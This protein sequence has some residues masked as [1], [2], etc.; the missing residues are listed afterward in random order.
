MYENRTMI[1]AGWG[2]QRA[3]YGEQTHWMIVTLAS[4][5]GQIGLPGGGFGFSYHYSNGGA[6]TTKGGKIGGITST[7]NSTQNTGGSSWH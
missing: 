5:L 4:M 1:M 6:P 2:I 3:Q 7:V